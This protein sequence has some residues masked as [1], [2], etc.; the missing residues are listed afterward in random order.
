MTWLDSVILVLQQFSHQLDRLEYLAIICFMTTVR[1]IL[2]GALLV[3]ATMKCWS[4]AKSLLVVNGVK[5]GKP[6]HPPPM[7]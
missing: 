4:L 2:I 3:W 7:L 6:D 5:S 1:V